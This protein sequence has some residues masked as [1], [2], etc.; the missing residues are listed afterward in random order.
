MGE[1]PDVD[2]VDDGQSADETENEDDIQDE[3]D[4]EEN[5]PGAPEK[6]E[7]EPVDAAALPDG[8]RG[9]PKAKGKAEKKR[10]GQD[11]PHIDTCCTPRIPANHASRDRRGH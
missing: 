2:D 5:A 8:V 10:A 4:N 11:R 1:A 9:K 7:P 3:G 6:T